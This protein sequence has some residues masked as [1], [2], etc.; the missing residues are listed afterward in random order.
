MPIINDATITIDDHRLFLKR[1]GQSQQIV[2][3]ILGQE[4]D[5]GIRRIYVDRLIHEPHE[6]SLDCYDCHGAIS[7]ILSNHTKSNYFVP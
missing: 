1:K 5:D 6:K 3:T 4:I 7:T 2:A